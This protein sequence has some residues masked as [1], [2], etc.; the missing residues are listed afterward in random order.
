M[1][2]RKVDYKRNELPVFLEKVRELIQEQD[3]EIEKAVISR[4][5]YVVNPEFKRLVKTKQEWFTKRTESAIYSDLLHSNFQRHLHLIN[6]WIFVM[7]LYLMMVQQHPPILLSQ[8]WNLALTVNLAAHIPCLT[9]ILI[10]SVNLAVLT[11]LG[12]LIH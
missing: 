11:P 3:D 9:P 7:A 4:G 12:N 1:L 2:K 10:F 5:K 8:A 6:H